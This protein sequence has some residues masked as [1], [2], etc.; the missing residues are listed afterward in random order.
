M[1]KITKI[2]INTTS[3]C[4]KLRGRK[5]TQ[6]SQRIEQTVRIRR[7]FVS[8]MKSWMGNN[9]KSRSDKAFILIMNQVDGANIHES[10]KVR[11]RL[12]AASPKREMLGSSVVQLRCLL[13]LWKNEAKWKRL[14]SLRCVGTETC[15]PANT[16]INAVDP[17]IAN[18]S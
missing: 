10:T 16:A 4:E 15:W 7:Y 18:I 1:T 8:L 11:R 14:H 12:M 3:K 9:N 6:G 5:L 2:M 13:P 17:L